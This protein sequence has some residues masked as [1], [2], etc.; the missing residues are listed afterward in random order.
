MSRRLRIP[1]Y[2]LAGAAGLAIVLVL[3]AV[4]VVRSEWFRD[5]VRARIAAEIGDSTGGRVELG[6]FGFNWRTL[7]ACVHNLVIH[8]AEPPGQAPLFRADSV[9][10]QLKILSVWKRRVDL[11]S[12]TVARPQVNFAVYPDGR[13]NLPTLRAARR[14]GKSPI[15]T[16]LDLTIKRFTVT[17]GAIHVQM[18]KLPL[19]VAGV[20]LRAQIFYEA[21][22]ARYRVGISFG[23]LNLPPGKIA[24]LPFDFEGQFL[25]ARNRIEITDARVGFGESS[26]DLKGTVQDFA[27]PRAD[28]RYT[29]H[30]LLK[31]LPAGLRVAGIARRGAISLAGSAV[32]SPGAEYM[33]T[34]R[35][36]AAGLEFE[37]RGIRIQNINAGSDISLTRGRLMCSHL[38][39]RALHGMFAGSAELEGFRDLRV[40]GDAQGFSLSELTHIPGVRRVEWN[41][42]ASGPVQVTAAFR[43][44]G[45]TQVTVQADLTISPASGPNPVDGR[46]H[47]TY[48]RRRDEFDLGQSRLATRFSRVQFYGVLGRRLE[49][50]IQSTNLNDAEPGIALFTAGP[51]PVMPVALRNG[52]ARFHG[53]LIGLLRG[54]MI[55]GHVSMMH[56]T[57][58]GRAYD[59]LDAGV[60]VSQ[61]GVIV[62]N[63]TLAAA[64]VHAAGNVQAGLRNWRPEPDQPLS[65]AFFVRATNLADMIAQSGLSVPFRVTSGAAK[66]SIS[67]AGKLGA[68]RISARAQAVKVVALGQPIERFEGEVSYTPGRLDIPSASIRM[69]AGQLQLS[70]SYTYLH[71]NWWQGSVR[72]Q[73]ATS[74]LLLARLK[75][76]EE[77]APGLS[78]RLE[79]QMSGAVA[80]GAAGFRPGALNGTVA[81]RSLALGRQPLGSLA[82]TAAT[83]GAALKVRLDGEVA[84][85]KVTGMSDWALEGQYPVKGRVDFTPLEFPALLALFHGPAG[86]SRRSRAR[87]RAVWNF[88]ARHSIRG[89]GKGPPNSPHSKCGRRK[90]WPELRT[91]RSSCYETRDRS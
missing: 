79:A 35:L 21:G 24:T 84:G 69:A 76:I 83:S 50:D 10:V 62:R 25:L 38:V 91:P 31:D 68:P 7:T 18:R 75:A 54:P 55:Q 70:G 12:V 9:Q 47:L 33:A 45:P 14:P 57:F 4:I 85:A 63:V 52:V 22:S 23:R 11:E 34:G 90:T 77:S 30:A 1:L 37:E 27:S 15:R 86:G 59:A 36:E 89:A 41:G 56:F 74:G 44:P 29:A 17:D 81:V 58:A 72:F 66:A 46:V 28:L 19:C 13:T 26:V 6:A 49:V 43:G 48:D 73:V 32:I 53:A 8:G 16:V 3:A 78:G 87:S 51:P 20:D 65:G 71:D 2:V 60:N 42:I 40:T 88:R 39:V 80:L 82:L 5:A 61:S 67:L 64:E